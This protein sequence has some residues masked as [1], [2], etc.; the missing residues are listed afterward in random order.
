MPLRMSRCILGK[1][2]LILALSTFALPLGWSQIPTLSNTGYTVSAVDLVHEMSM[3][4]IG[5]SPTIQYVASDAF[6]LSLHNFSYGDVDATVHL[7]DPDLKIADWTYDLPQ[8]N[9]G[10][11]FEFE[12]TD[13]DG[14]L[15]RRL[16]DN[17]VIAFFDAKGS[18][19]DFVAKM[20]QY[21]AE[22]GANRLILPCSSCSGERP[23]LL[24]PPHLGLSSTRTPRIAWR[25]FAV[26]IGTWV[27][28]DIWAK[29]S[30]DDRETYVA[31]ASLRYKTAF[32][33]VYSR[34]D[35]DTEATLTR[36][37]S[38]LRDALRNI[39]V[40]LADESYSVLYETFGASASN[41]GGSVERKRQR[42]EDSVWAEMAVENQEPECKFPVC[43]ISLQVVAPYEAVLGANTE[44]TWVSFE[45]MLIADMRSWG[46]P[47]AQGIF[48]EPIVV[49]IDGYARDSGR[50][51]RKAPEPDERFICPPYAATKQVFE[52][53]IAEKITPWI[54]ASTDS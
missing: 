18:D 26:E 7:R 49:F 35:S 6:S 40:R 21:M 4:D 51:G 30:S 41:D 17:D 1:S 38:A 46:R 33:D 15:I 36:I 10:P 11:K 44:Q 34:S 54:R 19:R 31:N 14:L 29:I 3:F 9:Q 5:Q 48:V 50:T 8:M 27:D 53:A 12:F 24:D 32:G 25:Q 52:D 13:S 45:I 20:G 2:A 22:L 43:Y 16:A 23:W 37:N 39:V 28:P 42:K 47:E